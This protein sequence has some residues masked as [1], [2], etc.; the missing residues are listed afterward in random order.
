MGTSGVGRAQTRNSYTLKQE[1][2]SRSYEVH[3]EGTATGVREVW[4]AELQHPDNSPCGVPHFQ[5]VNTPL[6]GLLPNLSGSH[7]PYL[8][9]YS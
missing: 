2:Q 8:A 9:T 6:R 4:K 3:R 7:T 1:E 5:S